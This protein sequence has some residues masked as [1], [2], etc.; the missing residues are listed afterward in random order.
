MVI[1]ALE[2]LFHR[3]EHQFDGR[4]TLMVVFDSVKD[5]MILVT[6]VYPSAAIA[7]EAAYAA[8]IERLERLV[9]ASDQPFKPRTPV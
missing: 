3:V 2:Y 9:A 5:E 7:P 4:P 6:P 8:A 1:P